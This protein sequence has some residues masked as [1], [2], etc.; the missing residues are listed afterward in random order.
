M[1][2]AKI[3]FS[4]V[5]QPDTGAYDWNIHGHFHNTDLRTQMEHEPEVVARLTKKHILIALEHTGY[6]PVN[7]KSL[8]E[9]HAHV[10]S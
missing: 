9:E 1:Y 7:L 4:H 10:Y 2:G 8:L 6:Q 5:P 3:L